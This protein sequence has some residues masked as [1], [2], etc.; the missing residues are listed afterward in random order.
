M[1]FG[2]KVQAD[3]PHILS[4]GNLVFSKRK[5]SKKTKNSINIY[6]RLR[7]IMPWE[8]DILSCAFEG[9]N[10][11]INKNGKRKNSYKFSKVFNPNHT[12]IQVFN[13]SVKP[14]LNHV[15]NGFNAI[16]MAYGQTGNNIIYTYIY[17]F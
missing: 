17:I 9:Q 2:F 8:G 16:F 11:V 10:K 4:V 5:M 1:A 6:A 7:K 15:L 13:D 3:L 14:M 12:N